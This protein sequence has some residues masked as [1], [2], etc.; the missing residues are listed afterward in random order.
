MIAKHYNTGY[1]Q[2][3]WAENRNG[4]HEHKTLKQAVISECSFHQ[5]VSEPILVSL[6]FV[7]ESTKISMVVP[8]AEQ[9]SILIF[10]WVRAGYRISCWLLILDIW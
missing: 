10:I 6:P 8:V 3:T 2:N 9:A 1:R 5:E 4:W 7:T